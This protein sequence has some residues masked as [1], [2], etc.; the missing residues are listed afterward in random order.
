MRVY[1]GQVELG[2]GII[3][4]SASNVAIIHTIRICAL[5]KEQRL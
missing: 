3:V 1:T 5:Q 2:R 4:L